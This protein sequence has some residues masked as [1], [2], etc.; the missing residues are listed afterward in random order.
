LVSC[1]GIEQLET[2]SRNEDNS[3]D[4]EGDEHDEGDEER[5]DAEESELEEED[6]SSD[7]P[8][9]ETEIEIESITDSNKTG[10]ITPV[11]N[12]EVTT[13]NSQA[14]EDAPILC[15]EIESENPNPVLRKEAE[16]TANNLTREL[17]TAEL[18]DCPW[19]QS[20]LSMEEIQKIVDH[21]SIKPTYDYLPRV[22]YVDKEDFDL[23]KEKDGNDHFFRWNNGTWR[24]KDSDKVPDEIAQEEV[25]DVIDEGVNEVIGRGADRVVN[26]V[27]RG[28]VDGGVVNEGANR[29]I[30]Q[31]ILSFHLFF[32]HRKGCPRNGKK[33]ENDG[34]ED[35]QV[36]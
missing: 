12:A 20:A 16:S 22:F 24:G 27:A 6:Y 15:P 10:M 7:L 1:N 18:A 21:L 28:G 14:Q 32:F 30:S 26:E 13:M 17:L 33:K 25:D 34:Q 2:I 23:W 19:I 4:H 11:L 9:S 3:T 29:N 8:D 5:T 36:G 31:E 35:G